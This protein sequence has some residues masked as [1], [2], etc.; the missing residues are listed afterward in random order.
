MT[1]A[2]VGIWEAQTSGGHGSK[3]GAAKRSLHPWSA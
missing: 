1:F 2:I 3:I